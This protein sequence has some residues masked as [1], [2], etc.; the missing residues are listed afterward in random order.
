[1]AESTARA[2]KAQFILDA[3]VE[4]DEVD[5]SQQEFVEYLIMQAQQYGMDPNQFAQAIDANNQVPGMLGEVARRK[6]L[7]GVLDR[8]TITDSAGNAVDLSELAPEGEDDEEEVVE[9]VADEASAEEVSAAAD[10]A[11]GEP[12]EAPAAEGYTGAHAGED[13]DTK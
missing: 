11:D 8:A 13:L 7:A 2:L 9:A 1:M 3:I 10:E 6:A 12:V 5:V 4:Q